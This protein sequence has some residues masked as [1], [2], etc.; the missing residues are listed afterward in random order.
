M[1]FSFEL[2]TLNDEPA[3]RRLLAST[4]MPG[5]ITVSFQREP[6]YFHGCPTMGAFWQVIV[7]RDQASGEIAGVMCRAV[8]P[9]WI[10][11]QQVDVGYVGQIRIAEAY[12]SRWLLWRGLDFFHELHSD[13][14]TAMYL[15]VISDENRISRGVLVEKA[16]RRYPKAVEVAHIYTSGIILTRPKPALVSPYQ[17][18]RGTVDQLPEIAAFLQAHGAQKQFFPVYTAS[19]LSSEITRDFRAEDFLIARDQGRIVGAIGL[20]DQAKYK[21]SIVYAYN[22]M[23]R[24]LRP[25]YN[26]GLAVMG[27]KPLPAIGEAIHSVYGSFICIEQNNPEI[28][29]VLLRHLYNLA[30]EHKAAYLMIGLSMD[31]PLLKVARAYNHIAYHSRAYLGSWEALPALDNRLLYIEIAML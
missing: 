30:I 4:P 9:C 7:A 14:S 23:L 15:G 2:A 3:L 16:S 19:D 21:Q 8:R 27:A 29:R 13:Q 10:N 1:H 28:F 26:L 22:G 20:W 12:R 24:W 17:I 25:A 31:D 18:T 6:N 11:G 5:S